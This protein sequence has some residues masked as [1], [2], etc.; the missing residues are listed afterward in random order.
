M[1]PPWVVRAVLPRLNWRGCNSVLDPCAGDCGLL[2]TV[3]D[4]LL[5]LRGFAGVG[6]R[7]A[8]VHGAEIDGHLLPPN[9]RH[10][11]ELRDSLGPMLRWNHADLVITNPPYSLAMEFV[12]R[13]LREIA[14]SGEVAMLLRLC[15]LAGQK[16]AA[17]HR[18]HPG[19]VY[20]L[21]KRPSFTG[22]GTDSADYAW[23]VW[24]PGRGNR[25]EVLDV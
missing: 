24:G 20:V 9:C 22:K 19:D 18:E 11:I 6:A 7:F 12:E 21:P 1:T 2:D 14:P 15:W 8:E 3:K 16:R 4:W 23:F 10:H 13:A 25:W 5:D 17:F